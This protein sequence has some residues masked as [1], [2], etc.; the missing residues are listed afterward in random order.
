[1]SVM[2]MH[3]IA[4]AVSSGEFTIGPS[5]KDYSSVPAFEEALDATLTGDVTGYIDAACLI[6]NTSFSGITTAPDKQV[7]VRVNAAYRHNGKFDITK[8]SSVHTN[9]SLV[10]CSIG[11]LTIDGYQV[12]TTASAEATFTNTSVST[13]TVMN[14]IIKGDRVT[15]NQW[16][17]F[18]GGTGNV[19]YLKNVLMY[20][21]DPTVTSSRPVFVNSSGGIM[22]SNHCTVYDSYYAWR[23][24]G[25]TF[26]YYNCLVANT[27]AS[28]FTNGSG[29]GDYNIQEYNSTPFGAN[30]KGNT[31]ITFM[32][33]SN[34]DFRLD[35]TETDVIDF[36]YDPAI[37]MISVYADLAG[38]VRPQGDA[39]DAGALE[40]IS[41][42]P[43]VIATEQYFE[44]FGTI[45][46]DSW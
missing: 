38:N 45:F 15:P 18:V 28:G 2:L 35:P 7:Y 10:N 21:F 34:G 31:S 24:N 4:F 3:S 20:N 13:M 42:T 11:H 17:F 33:E 36:G 29:G 14:T 37:A 41:A 6:T 12:Y 32:D 5:G 8:A 46:E 43:P 40:H 19:C 1:M 23:A 39:P 30:S 27:T 44:Y 22:Y 9:G 25:G 16:C 26:Y